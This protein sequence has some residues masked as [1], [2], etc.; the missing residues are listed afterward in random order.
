MR[1]FSGLY[2]FFRLEGYFYHDEYIGEEPNEK[3]KQRMT[4][5]NARDENDINAVIEP[6]EARYK[7]SYLHLFRRKCEK[8][9][10]CIHNVF[11]FHVCYD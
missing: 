3:I 7:N 11:A 10:A 8:C 4:K 9:H 5:K 6:T 1:A 2:V